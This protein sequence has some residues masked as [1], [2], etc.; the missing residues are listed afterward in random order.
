MEVNVPDGQKDFKTDLAISM[1][2]MQFSKVTME[3]FKDGTYE[4]SVNVTGS[5]T[6][7]GKYWL[8]SDNKYICTKQDNSDKEKRSQIV[9]ISSDTLVIGDEDGS[10]VMVRVEQ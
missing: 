7:H 4:S 3:Y 8:E 2:E 6:S 9:R 10:I 1:A 5:E